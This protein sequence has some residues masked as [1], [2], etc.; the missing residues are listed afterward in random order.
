[1]KGSNDSN[2]VIIIII[3]IIVI[4]III[5]VVSSVINAEKSCITPLRCIMQKSALRQINPS[6]PLALGIY[7]A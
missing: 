1:M 7:L 3:I 6:G 4:I 2:K 5:I